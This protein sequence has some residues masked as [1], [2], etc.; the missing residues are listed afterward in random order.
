MGNFV[1]RKLSVFSITNKKRCCA[2]QRKI[3][4]YQILGLRSINDLDFILHRVH[5]SILVGSFCIATEVFT[6][7]SNES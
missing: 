6:I 2:D 3:R 5:S 7:C 1:L 4:D